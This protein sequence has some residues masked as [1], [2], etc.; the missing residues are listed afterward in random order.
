MTWVSIGIWHDFLALGKWSSTKVTE[1]AITIIA[2]MVMAIVLESF[3]LL[4]LQLLTS[5]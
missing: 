4:F 2:T 5:H 3:G 1:A